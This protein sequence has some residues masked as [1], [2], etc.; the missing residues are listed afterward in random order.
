MK[1][2]DQSLLRS[3]AYLNGAWIDADNA[4][5]F[6]VTNPANGE[7]ITS[8]PDLGAAETRRAIDAANDAWPAWRERPAKERAILIRRWF[9]LVMEHQQDLARILSWEQGKPLA[10]AM[11]EIAYGASFIEWFGEEAK[12]VYGDVIPNTLPDRRLIVIKQPIGVV[13]AIT[14][15]N[16]PTAMITRKA[17]PAL[18]A[19]C[20]IIVKPAAET[21]LSALALAEL[22]DRAGIPPGIFN[23]ITT[24]RAAEVGTEMTSNPDVRKISFTGSTA[25]GKLLMRQSA[26]TVKKMS[27]ELGGNAPF[28]VFDDADLDAAVA[29]AMASKYRNSGQTCVCANR[30]IVQDS[31]YEAFAAKL[32]VAVEALQVGEATEDNVQQG[33]LINEAAVE[34]VEEHISDA[35]Q[36]GAKLATGGKRHDRGGTFFEP[37]VLLNVDNSMKVAVEETFGPVA[38]IFRFSTEEEAIALANDTEFGLAAYFYARDIGRVWRVAEG[39]DTGIVGINEGIISTEVAPFGGVK[40]SGLGRE[41]SKYGIEDFIEIKYLCM[42]IAG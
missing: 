13:C 34:K 20:P 30:L 14:P 8:V 39:L 21:P 41:G 35:L 23:V 6:E 16:F 24:N 42:G 40:E 33:P 1:I 4:T 31:V 11:G 7:T 28:I 5:S 25:I 15:W 17:A 22:A 29:G 12:R 32:A 27:L 10:E 19:G 36:K 26:D 38:P 18:A 2:T 9:D 37:T 3:Q